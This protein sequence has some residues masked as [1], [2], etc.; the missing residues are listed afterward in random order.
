MGESST[1]KKII[2]YCRWHAVR[3]SIR[4]CVASKPTCGPNYGETLQPKSKIETASNF[5]D[6]VSTIGL[7]GSEI[8]HELNPGYLF[9]PKYL[10]GATAKYI[11]LHACSLPAGNMHNMYNFSCNHRGSEGARASARG[12]KFFTRSFICRINRLI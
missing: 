3:A 7:Q 5:L 9:G 10:L 2:P 12:R 11:R 4:I 1:S 8:W 6:G